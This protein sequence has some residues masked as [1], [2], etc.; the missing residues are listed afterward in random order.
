MKAERGKRKGESGSPA[1]VGWSLRI[2]VW[3]P[4]P[5][6]S[7]YIFFKS[8][9]LYFFEKVPKTWAVVYSIRCFLC[10]RV[11][12]RHL[13]VGAHLVVRCLSQC[14]GRQEL[15]MLKHHATFSK[16]CS[17]ALCASQR[18][19]LD[20]LLMLAAKSQT[21]LAFARLRV[22]FHPWRGITFCNE[23]PIAHFTAYYGNIKET[24]APLKITAWTLLVYGNKRGLFAVR[25]V[26]FFFITP[27]RTS[28]GAP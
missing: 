17:T 10:S 3:S 12:M 28:S 8:F 2:F 20:K 6:I 24:P 7:F 23:S 18:S 9:F 5:L 11:A 14:L 15:A 22:T 21:S 1:K 4:Q 26:I 25:G 16:H 13:S 19:P 27:Y